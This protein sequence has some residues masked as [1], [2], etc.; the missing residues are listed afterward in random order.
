M[1]TTQIHKPKKGMTKKGY[2]LINL[3]QFEDEPPSP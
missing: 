3:G 1:E 2:I